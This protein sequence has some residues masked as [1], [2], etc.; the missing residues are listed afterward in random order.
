V[1][2]E[3]ALHRRLQG[4]GVPGAAVAAAAIFLPSFAL[5]LLILPM[6]ERV[7]GLAWTRAAMQGVGPALIGVLAVTLV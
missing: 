6:F 2:A 5:M 7:S 1:G 3:G 4:R